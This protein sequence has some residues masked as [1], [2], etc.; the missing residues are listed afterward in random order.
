M[1]ILGRIFGRSERQKSAEV[2][3]VAE[4]L[5]V[6]EPVQV[7]TVEAPPPV[8][9]RD[10]LPS[11]QPREAP[12]EPSRAAGVKS[13]ML[14]RGDLSILDLRS[15]QFKRTRIVGSAY[16]VTERERSRYGGTEYLLVRE[17]TNKWD[18]Y[19]V[20]VYGRGRKVG[21]LSEAKAA[22]FAPILDAL[23]YDGY[24]V[25]GASVSV[26]SIRLWVDLPSI[27]ALRKFANEHAAA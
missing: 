25:G 8:Q 9:P 24:T 3:K 22:A 12:A 19:A 10:V 21:H 7:R 18:Q 5:P 26:N 17:P 16:W 15:V 6:A 23:G 11:V 1:G 14:P 13:V 2:A 27:P 4:S 20:A